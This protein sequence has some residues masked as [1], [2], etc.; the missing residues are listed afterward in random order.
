MS[1]SAT[2]LT[3]LLLWLGR[4]NSSIKASLNMMLMMKM[5]SKAVELYQHHLH[6]LTQQATHVLVLGG[7]LSYHQPA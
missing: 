2:G 7:H 5:S 3:A 6:Q 4:P 1:C